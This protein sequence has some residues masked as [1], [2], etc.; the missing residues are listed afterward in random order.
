LRQARVLPLLGPVLV[1]YL[2]ADAASGS[3]GLDLAAWAVSLSALAASVL[4]LVVRRQQVGEGT[5]RVQLL[6]VALGLSV[7]PLISTSLALEIARIGGL[8]LASVVLL[9][10]SLGVPDAPRLLDRGPLGRLLPALVAVVL[11]VLATLAILPSEAAGDVLVPARWADAP[12]HLLFAAMLLALGLRLSRRSLG[13]TPEALARNAWPVFG[14]SVALVATGADRVVWATGVALSPTLVRSLPVI[15]ALA[16]TACHVPLVDDRRG[17]RS[18]ETIRQAITWTLTLATVGALGGL[19]TIWRPTDAFDV[20]LAAMLLVVLGTALHRLLGRL[21]RHLFAPFGGRLLVGIADAEA[22]L[23]RVSSVVELGRSLLPPLRD[24]SDASEA[25]PLLYA[26]DPAL[27]I[28]VDAAGEAHVRAQPLP[29]A[30]R[31]RMLERPGEILIRKALES[32]VVRRPALRGVVDALVSF[33]ALAAVPLSIDGELEGAII[34][35]R[36]R[37]RSAPALEELRALQGLADRV[38]GLVALLAAER[39]AQGRA[40]DGDMQQR[41]LADR[42]EVLEEERDRLRAEARQWKAGRPAHR[43]S[44]TAVAYS[45][46]MRS[47]LDRVNDVASLDAPVLLRAEG[48]A[49]VDQVAHA[50]HGASGRREGPLV[51]ADCAAL[52]AERAAAALF[53]E[54]G[55]GGA[56]RPGWLSLAR[57]GSVLLADVV[58]LPLSVQHEL[59]ESLAEREIRPVGGSGAEPIDVR[60]I[61]ASRVELGALVED[62]V[63]DTELARWLSP[64]TLEVPPLRD[65]IEDIPSLTLLALDRASRL[66]GRAPIGIDDDALGVLRAYDWPGN[67]RELTWVITRAVAGAMGTT[68]SASELPQL[69]PGPELEEDGHPLDGTWAELERRILVRA[70]AS[71]DGN[72]SE[73]ARLLGLKRTT[74]LD[75]LRRHELAPPAKARESNAAAAR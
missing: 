29:E 11:G 16:V 64:L 28:R 56:S 62:G 67:V 37:R 52:R 35:P 57:G 24:A 33:D 66:L 58:A 49:S 41:D 47:L 71:A 2:I 31:E 44:G 9:D 1:L 27:E 15:T 59:A 23:G 72:K 6:G 63:F 26:V 5:R 68:L 19:L 46:A 12:D 70:L 13:S 36:G 54:V 10:L 14:L 18:G 17:P 38:S 3:S 65:R 39:R 48:G 50:I 60:V 73:A 7:L 32:L 20:A 4:P 40:G 21:T 43:M 25:N 22:R 75:K 61:A 55:E 34:V 42:I 51:V 74:F 30:L 53:G 45:A 69:S 8:T